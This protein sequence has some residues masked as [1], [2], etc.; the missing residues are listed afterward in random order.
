M[1]FG[2]WGSGF[3]VQGLGFGFWYR[4]DVG[5]G[6]VFRGIRVQGAQGSR[7][8]VQEPLPRERCHRQARDGPGVQV[9]RFLC[10]IL[11]H[12]RCFESRVAEVNSPTNPSTYPLLLPT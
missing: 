1:R 5:G 3:G 4:V 9:K 12:T 11:S 2:V 8:R 7:L 6:S 10:A